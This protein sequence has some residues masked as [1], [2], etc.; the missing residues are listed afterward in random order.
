MNTHHLRFL[1]R[2]GVI[3]FAALAIACSDDSDG[4]SNDTTDAGVTDAGSDAGSSDDG[5]SAAGSD[6]SSSGD[7]SGSSIDAGGTTTS[8]PWGEP[9]PSDAPDE[10]D[11][12]PHGHS[13]TTV[14]LP[15]AMT[16]AG[17]VYAVGSGSVASAL[18]QGNFKVP[19]AGANAYG[20]TWKAAPLND[21]GVLPK[22]GANGQTFWLV[23]D[24]KVKAAT[25]AISSVRNVV[26]VYS[27]KRQL[28]GDLYGHDM[29]RVPVILQPNTPFAAR[30]RGGRSIRVLLEKT[31]RELWL[32]RHDLTRPDLR[33]GQQDSLW[34]GMPLLSLSAKN[35]TEIHASV[36]ETPDFKPST[37]S[38]AGIGPLAVSH[39]GF[40]LRPKHKWPAAGTKE[41]PVKFK[42]KLRVEAKDSAAAYDHELELTVINADDPFRQTFRS[43]VD[44]SIQYYGV[45]PPK[46]FDATETYAMALSLHGAGVAGI[47]QAKSYGPKDWIYIIA[48]TNRRRFGF[49]HEEWGHLNDLGAMHDAMERFKIDP[50]RRYITGH[51]MGGHGTWQFGIHH[52]SYFNVVGPSAGWDSF[53]TYG[54]S[55]KPSFPTSRARAHSDTSRYIGNLANRSVYVIHGTKDNNVPWSEGLAM[56][57]KSKQVSKDVH[58]HWQIGAG[59]WWDNDKNTPGA[60]CVDW[61]PLF[62]LM[63]KRTRDP[64]ELSFTFTS[65]GPWYSDHYSYVRILSST[66]PHV[67]CV[68][69]ST[70][71]G[72]TLRLKTGNVRSMVING[73][74]I[75]SKGPQGIEIDGKVYKLTDDTFVIGPTTGKRP[76]VHGPFNQVMHRPWC[77]VYDKGDTAYADF[78]AFLSTHWAI[79]GNGHGCVLEA[80][81][82]TKKTRQRYNYIHLG[83][84]HTDTGA[85][86]SLGWDNDGVTVGGKSF[87]GSALQS[88]WDNGKG[89][90]AIIVAPKGS[91]YLLTAVVPFSSRS[92]MPDF[93]VWSGNKLNAGGYFDADWKINKT[94]AAGL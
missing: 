31:Q 84:A 36:L 94:Y 19:K 65:P 50:N 21:K 63:K 66:S 53:Y 54:K 56:H 47:G 29:A 80:G 3:A 87:P 72:A 37:T 10:P 40:H 85:P 28:P 79:I 52:A 48:P 91:E 58:K 8:F 51:S 17:W 67:D 1:F 81:A 70:F 16:I 55:P 22:Q 60:A 45:R 42:V 86:S 46:P 64:A 27:G 6:G 92:G 93:L 73:K 24:P 39:I 5:G 13:A 18:S 4:G 12:K 41:K 25:P 62:D 49:D 23:V 44:R 71:D 89:L 76:G 82:L 57:T 11:P 2:A 7:A 69:Q 75:R 15:Q 90:D 83:R 9:K 30:G 20:L 88:I 32:N 14:P 78:A 35:H 68:L 26:R 34:I 38:W 43:H 59:H 61:K 74:L 33:A 77:W